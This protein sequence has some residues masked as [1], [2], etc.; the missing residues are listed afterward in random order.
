M[1]RASIEAAAA[2]PSSGNSR[3]TKRTLPVSIYFDFSIGST[4]WSNAAQCEQVIEV[5][6]TMV[7]GA[8]AG[9][10]AMSGSETG[11]VTR[12]A[13]ALCA[14]ASPVSCRDAQPARPSDNAVATRRGARFKRSAPGRPSRHA[15]IEAVR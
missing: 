12:T 3:N 15:V 8:P 11:L 14:P 4:V 10:R 9:P 1:Q 6:S 7:T 13:V 5:Y 2:L